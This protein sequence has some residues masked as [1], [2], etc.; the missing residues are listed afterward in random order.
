MRNLLPSLST[1]LALAIAGFAPVWRADTLKTPV[2]FDGN[3]GREPL[4]G[5]ILDTNDNLFGTTQSGGLDNAGTVFEIA[6]NCALLRSAPPTQGR[7]Q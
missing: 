3:D 6:K 7:S 1:V 4:A 2:S 5:L